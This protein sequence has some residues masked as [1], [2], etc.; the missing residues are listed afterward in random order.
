MRVNIIVDTQFIANSIHKQLCSL[1]VDVTCVRVS[2]LHD[3]YL[4]FLREQLLTRRADAHHTTINVQIRVHIWR[5]R[6]SFIKLWE[7]KSA[8][9][10]IR[11]EEVNRRKQQKI[12][13][14]KRF[15]QLS[16]ANKLVC[17]PTYV[18]PI[19]RIVFGGWLIETNLIRMPFTGIVT[20]IDLKFIIE[21]W[22]KQIESFHRNPKRP[23]CSEERVEIISF[24][25]HKNKNKTELRHER[26]RVFCCS[27]F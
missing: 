21:K 25:E 20:S 1:R 11:Q 7:N 4:D 6:E 19:Y 3:T 26:N 5:S 24:I 17:C 8:A 10:K 22:N 13:R 27:A 16:R 15:G 9:S 2:W 12:L 18:V 23:S 14:E